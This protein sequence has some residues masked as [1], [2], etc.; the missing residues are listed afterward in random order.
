MNNTN[1][2]PYTEYVQWIEEALVK[3]VQLAPPYLTVSIRIFD[4]GSSSTAQ[5]MDED[6]NLSHPTEKN[7]TPEQ[8]VTRKSSLTSSMLLSLRGV[9]MESGRSDLDALLKEEV[10]MASGS[11][12]V[13]GKHL[14]L[15]P[16]RIY[17]LRYYISLRVARYSTR[18][19]SCASFPGLWTF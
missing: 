13:S 15:R 9:K 8:V 1:V 5:S 10:S 3:A 2:I 12:S 17:N 16:P 4:T 18:S 19:P 7:G 14:F 6:P 11:M